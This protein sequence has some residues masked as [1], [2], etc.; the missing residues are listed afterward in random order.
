MLYQ[1][2]TFKID[3]NLDFAECIIV[4]IERMKYFVECITVPKTKRFE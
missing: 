3:G 1:I 2:I 4:L